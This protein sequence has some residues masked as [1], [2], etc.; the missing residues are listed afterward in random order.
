VATAV[1]AT[2]TRVHPLR[3]ASWRHPEWPW[4]VLAASA[5][6]ILIAQDAITAAGTSGTSLPSHHPTVGWWMLMTIAMMIPAALPILREISLESLWERRYLAAATFLVGYLAVWGAF[7]AAALLTWSLA[8]ASSSAAPF[9]GGAALLVGALWGLTRAKRRSL[10]RCHR[11]VPLPPRGRTGDRACLHFGFYN[12]R[13][14]VGVCWPVML[15]MVPG[16]ALLAMLG[17]TALVTWERMAR[18]P[19][20]RVTASILAAAGS[21]TVLVA[22]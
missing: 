6:S 5:W 20:L 9:L 4:A 3:R 10:Q 14:C 21:I 17:V 2:P 13:Q 1:A 7:G 8:G 18:L 12:A 15:A 16:H 19:R 11:Y 22:V